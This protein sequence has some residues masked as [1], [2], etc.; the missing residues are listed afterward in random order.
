MIDWVRKCA[1]VH[2]LVMYAHEISVLV[3]VTF[4]PH[5]SVLKL[6]RFEA[7]RSATANHFTACCERW[8]AEVDVTDRSVPHAF[9]YGVETWG[10]W[11]I[12]RGWIYWFSREGL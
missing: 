3:V 2:F 6:E 7:I 10:R 1:L 9:A 12:E 8:I 5:S 4:A 11:R